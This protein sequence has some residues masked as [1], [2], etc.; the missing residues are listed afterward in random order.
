MLSVPFPNVTALTRLSRSGLT[1]GVFL[2]AV[3]QNSN[4]MSN[5]DFNG[6][7]QI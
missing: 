5:Y 6:W 7:M 3:E 4:I 2:A 1:T